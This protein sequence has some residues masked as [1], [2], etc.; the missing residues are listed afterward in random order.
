MS[1]F[2]TGNFGEANDGDGVLA[3]VA[4]P[5]VVEGACAEA[6]DTFSLVRADDDVGECTAFFDDEHGVSAPGLC[7]VLTHAG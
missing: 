7:L 4:V 1:L 2:L 5:D 3:D 6:V